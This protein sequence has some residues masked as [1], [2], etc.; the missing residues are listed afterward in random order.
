[1]GHGADFVLG[2]Q[3]GRDMLKPR[4]QG[5]VTLVELMV[6]IAVVAIVLAMGAPSFAL[7]LQNAQNRVAAESIQSGMQLARAE[8]VKRNTA[9][10]FTL[11]DPTGLV[12]WSVGCVTVGDDCPASIQRREAAEGSANAR[13]GVSTQAIPSPLPAGQFNSALA[14]GAGLSAGVS[15][16]GMG[17]VP[18]A[19]IGTD[20]T[21]AD[22]TNAALP[23]A[24]RLVI[25]VGTG[26]QV[27][28]CDPAVALSASP[29]GCM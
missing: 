2:H 13:V 19:N 11:T 8:A 27:R 18:A 5:G 25:V 21:R 3:K 9:V 1:M 20:I 15:F 24:R 6:G 22:V 14:A 16:D 26:G 23:S 4:R 28:M 7:W 10:R 17:R 12:A 29:Q